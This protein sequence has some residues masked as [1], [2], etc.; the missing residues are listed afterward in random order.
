[1]PLVSFFISC[2]LISCTSLPRGQRLHN[3]HL[4]DQSDMVQMINDQGRLRQWERRN[5][6]APLPYKKVMRTFLRDDRG[7]QRGLITSYYPNGQLMQSLE[8]C[9]GRAFGAYKEWFDSGQL[10]LRAQVAGGMADLT[11]RAQAEWLFEGDCSAW[12]ESGQKAAQMHY[13]G[14]LRQGIEHHFW[15][16]GG[17]RRELTHVK[18]TLHGELREFDENGRLILLETY[19][20]GKRSG[21]ASCYWSSGRQAWQEIRDQERLISASYWDPQG[22]LLAKINEGSGWRIVFDGEAISQRQRFEQGWQR[23]AIDYFDALGSLMRRAHFEQG[24]LE[25]LDTEFFAVSKEP[26]AAHGALV[27]P[28]PSLQVTW[29]SGVL[30]GPV[31]TWFPNGQLR[32]YHERVHNKREGICTHYY[33]DGQIKLVEHYRSDQL[34]QGQYFGHREIKARSAVFDGK[35]VAT[36]FDDRGAVVEQI[37]YE[38]GMPISTP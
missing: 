3:I 16:N 37:A 7:C 11:P 26:I 32:T 14:G 13:Q 22:L 18:G 2:L 1:M 36:L 17:L 38:A 4:I 33:P 27:D 23:G 35:G 21:P 25:G 10:R 29:S 12:D 28:Q 9:D 31:K 30:R 20:G 6:D 8:T 24:I 34:D 15:P 5:F 19:R